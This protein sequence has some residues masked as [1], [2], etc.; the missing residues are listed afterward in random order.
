MPHHVTPCHTMPHHAA[1]CHTM[2]HQS[3]DCLTSI[4]HVWGRFQISSNSVMIGAKFPKRS[5]MVCW[6]TSVRDNYSRISLKRHHHQQQQH[7]HQLS[8]SARSPVD[9]VGDVGV[10]GDTSWGW[11][12]VECTSPSSSPVPHL[13]VLKAF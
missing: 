7:P 13:E 4:V 1:P 5:S 9:D 12:A 6:F 10:S 8:V 3:Q 11:E 2:S